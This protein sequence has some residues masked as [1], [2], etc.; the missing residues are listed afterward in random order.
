V[1]AVRF[2]IAS[3]TLAMTPSGFRSN[4]WQLVL[5]SAAFAD[6]QRGIDALLARGQIVYI[7]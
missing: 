6:R 2:W 4:N 1:A 5:R 3:L 7:T